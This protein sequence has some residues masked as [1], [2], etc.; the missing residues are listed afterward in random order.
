[1]LCS[2]PDPRQL[3]KLVT[4]QLDDTLA[5][6]LEA[7]PER[8]SALPGSGG[9]PAR[10][11]PAG[12]G[13]PGLGLAR[14][15]ASARSARC[16][17]TDP[18]P[19]QAA[20]RH[21]LAALFRSPVPGPGPTSVIRWEPKLPTDTPPELVLPQTGRYRLIRLLGE[22]GMGSVYLGE[23]PQLRRPV[24]VKIPTA[25]CLPKPGGWLAGAF[26]MKPGSLPRS[27][28]PTSVPSMTSARTPT[29]PM[30]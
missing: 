6:P 28:I 14:K 2:C 9:Q 18:E 25:P 30:W 10:E 24:A 16:P 17:G 4:G 5:P 7:A 13:R 23:D 29:L 3:Q 27:V 11:R 21:R 15:S 22:G 1:M 26:R 20:G 19:P 12:A 8:V